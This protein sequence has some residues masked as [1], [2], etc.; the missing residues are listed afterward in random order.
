MD[1]AIHNLDFARHMF[2]EVERV[3]ACTMTFREDATA[4]DTGSAL[5]RYASGDDLVLSWSWGLPL[6]ARGGSVNDIIGPKGA[7]YFSRDARPDFASLPA[8][9]T[10]WGAIVVDAGE[11][12]IQQYPYKLNDMYLDEIQAF[13]DAVRE[14]GPSP[15]DGE[16]GIGSLAI[17]EAILQAGESKATIR[18]PLEG[19]ISR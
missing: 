14:G 12:G 11:A 18:G 16:A 13:V 2:G 7:L 6:G 9:D 1:G 10:G 17:A 15:I 19:G 3:A 4:A 5:V 8:L